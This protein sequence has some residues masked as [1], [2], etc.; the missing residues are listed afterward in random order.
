[1]GGG[2]FFVPVRITSI[3]RLQRSPDMLDALLMTFTFSDQR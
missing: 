2:R 3:A 1:M